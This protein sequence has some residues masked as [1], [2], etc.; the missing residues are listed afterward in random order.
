M[1]Y[2]IMIIILMNTTI[3]QEVPSYLKD[4]KISV[5]L[6]DGKVYNFSA[7]EYMVV[8]RN[9]ETKRLIEKLQAVEVTDS[10]QKEEKLTPLSLFLARKIEQLEKNK[11]RQSHI[12]S[13]ELVESQYGL[14][15]SSY[16]NR[17][18]VNSKTRL[19]GGVMYQ[20]NIYKDLYLGGRLDS[21]G[22]KGLNIGLGF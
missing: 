19:G 9:S 15:R 1:K 14:N 3:A 4:G 8:K 20:N 18:F 13:I 2:L 7:N 6:T 22:A 12:V 11:P 17:T 16:N 21:N 10:A 5:T